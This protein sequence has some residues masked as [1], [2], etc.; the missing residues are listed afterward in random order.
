MFR[1]LHVMRS[2][3]AGGIGTFIMNVYREIDRSKIQFDFAITHEGMGEYG[4]EIVDLGGRIF[5]IS[6]QGNEHIVDGFIQVANLYE[7]CRKEHFDAIHCHYYFANAELL[8]VAKLAGIKKRVSHCHN[9][10]TQKIGVARKI[11]EYFSR[12]LLLNVGTDFLGCSLAAANFLYGRKTLENSK[13]KVLYNGI[14]Y[15]KWGF[16]EEDILKLKKKYSVVGNRVCIF[17]GRFEEQKNPFFA[18]RVFHEIYKSDPSAIFIMVGYGSM[19]DDIQKLII[20]LQ[21]SDSARIYP[22][23]SNIVELQAIADIMIAPSLWEGLSI[24]FIEAQKMGTQVFT[25]DK[26]PSE[27]NMG[28]CKFLPLELA[29]WKSSINTYIVSIGNEPKLEYDQQKWE[30]FDVKHTAKELLKVYME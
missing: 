24:A 4:Q 5:F 12:R 9:T 20:E 22:A 30:L 17:I 8:L 13:A 21:L 29:L 11:F 28:Y 23:D 7:L 19:L 16:I 26:V 27:V 6:K 1:V 14:N 10:R 18:I 25:S 2:L 15:D 3:K